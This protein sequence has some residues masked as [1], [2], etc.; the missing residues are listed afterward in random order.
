MCDPLS[1]TASVLAVAGFAVKASECLYRTLRLLSETPDDL[2]HHITA[3]QALQSTF[4]GIVALG[5]D[6]QNAAFITTDLKDRLQA[7]ILDLQAM[8]RLARSF[9]A[10]HGEGKARRTWS[11]MR[12]SLTDQRQTLKSHLRRIESYHMRFSLE[13]LLINM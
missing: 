4:A 3:I 11:K 1:V 9:H 5:N 2:H 8:E 7:C 13:L 6:A 10:Q 12:G